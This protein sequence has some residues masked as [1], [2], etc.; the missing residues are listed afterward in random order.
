MGD[1]NVSDEN[2]VTPIHFFGSATCGTLFRVMLTST[3][4]HRAAMPS[5]KFLP[6][7]VGLLSACSVIAAPMVVTP[8]PEQEAYQPAG[9]A[10]PAEGAARSAWMSGR[11]YLGAGAL[12]EAEKA[13]L[14]ADRKS[15]V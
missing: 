13:F 10:V 7:L 6:Q 5:L 12:D 9:S 11:A 8:N 1:V 14:E 3:T 15:V 2:T 4:P